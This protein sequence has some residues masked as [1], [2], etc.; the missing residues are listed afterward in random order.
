MGSVERVAV[1]TISTPA[2]AAAELGVATDSTPNDVTVV[3]KSVLCSRLGDQTL[4]NL[5]GNASQKPLTW[6][7]A[8]RPLPR[9]ARR[10]ESGRASW[11]AAKTDVAVV[12]SRLR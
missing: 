12:R 6:L 4:T 3:A 8:C 5:I 2:T 1:T 7:K 11:R 9:T 10:D